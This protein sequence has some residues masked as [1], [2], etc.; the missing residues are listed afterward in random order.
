MMSL[1]AAVATL[2]IFAGWGVGK[3]MVKASRRMRLTPR[4]LF[5]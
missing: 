5:F 3:Q 2:G 1:E 4:K